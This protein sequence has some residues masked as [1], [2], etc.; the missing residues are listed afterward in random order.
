MYAEILPS[1]L[2]M[3]LQEKCDCFVMQF[4]VKKYFDRVDPLCFAGKQGAINTQTS[5]NLLTYFGFL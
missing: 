2:Q 1:R 5:L 4:G 3:F